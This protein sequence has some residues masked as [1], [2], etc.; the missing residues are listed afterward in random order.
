MPGNGQASRFGA[1]LGYHFTDGGLYRG[2]FAFKGMEAREDNQFWHAYWRQ[3]LPL[4]SIWRSA[5]FQ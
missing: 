3:S 4:P 5:A 2:F 1:C